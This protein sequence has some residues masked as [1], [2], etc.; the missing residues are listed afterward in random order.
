MALAAWL[1]ATQVAVALRGPVAVVHACT[2]VV[3][4]ASALEHQ[5]VAYLDVGLAWSAGFSCFCLLI[6]SKLACIAA[7]RFFP[8]AEPST[9]FS[10][11]CIHSGKFIFLRKPRKCGWIFAYW[12]Y[13]S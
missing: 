3:A 8:F 5:L 9:T 7:S 13:I 6:L 4:G 10:M 11:L 12:K 1:K 2:L